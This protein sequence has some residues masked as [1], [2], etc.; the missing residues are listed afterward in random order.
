VAPWASRRGLAPAGAAALATAVAIILPGPLGEPVRKLAKTD[1]DG[2]RPRYSAEVDDAAIRRAGR[3]LPNDTTYFLWTTG[4]SPLLQGNLKAATE[5]YLGP[6]LPVQS[7][8][9]AGWVLSY[10]ART[11]LPPGAQAAA[12]YRLGPRIVLARLAGP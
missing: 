5:L 1:G 2:P 4:A 10:G 9:G 8:R 7:P 6:A 12:R 11:E 3:L